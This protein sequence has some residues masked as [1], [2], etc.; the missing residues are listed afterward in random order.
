MNGGSKTGSSYIPPLGLERKKSQCACSIPFLIFG[1][2]LRF[3][4]FK[5]LIRR[6]NQ[7][8]SS[9]RDVWRLI[10]IYIYYI[11]IYIISIL[12]EIVRMR[13]SWRLIFSRFLRVQI[14]GYSMQSNDDPLI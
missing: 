7:L 6:S 3:S 11:Y 1:S 9:V 2:G 14:R 8:R 13:V 10:C 4:R 5:F 12:S